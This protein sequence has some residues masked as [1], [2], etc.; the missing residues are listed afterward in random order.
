MVFF[1]GDTEWE[2]ARFV[3]EAIRELQK[4]EGWAFRDVAIL[5]P[6]PC[7]FPGFGGRVHAQRRTLPHHR[8]LAFL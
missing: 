1:Q 2:E 7:P 5:V 3:A 8:W 6:D 4:E